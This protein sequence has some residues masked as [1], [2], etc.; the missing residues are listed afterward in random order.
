MEEERLHLGRSAWQTPAQ[1]AGL[2]WLE[3]NGLGGW[4]FGTVPNLNTRFYHGV[5]APSLRPPTERIVLLAKVDE[6]VVL[7]GQAHPLYSNAWEGGK[8]EAGGLTY[9]HSFALDPFPTWTFMIGDTLIRKRLFMRHGSNTTVIRYHVRRGAGRGPVELKLFPL[10]TC[11]TI[12]G[13]LRQ[14]DWPFSQEL[15][16]S[17][18]VS[19]E[20]YVG[21]PRL[22]MAVD[23]GSYAMG[24]EWVV[25][26]H[27]PYEV[28]RGEHTR[29]DLYLPGSFTWRCQG[30]GELTFVASTDPVGLIDGES[31]EDGERRRRQA[32]VSQAV[33]RDRFTAA[34]VQAAD[35]FIV[36]RESTGT[37]T[38]IAGYPWFTDW[39][40]DTMI[41]L[42]GLTLST[43]RYHLARQLLHTFAAYERDGLIPNCFPEEGAEP[44]YNTADASLWFSEAVWQYLRY[45]GDDRFVRD[46]LYPVLLR[47]AEAHVKGTRFD[48]RVTADGLLRCGNPGVQVTWMDA[49][50][51]NWVVT[52]RDGRPVE[53]QALWYNALCVLAELSRRYDRQE[54]ARR[55]GVMADQVAERFGQ[56][57]WNEAEGCCYDLLADDGCPD[58]S[59]RPNQLFTMTLAHPLI[60]GER[61]RSTVDVLFRELWTPY[62]LRSLSPRDPAYKGF[63]EGNRR[64]RDGAYHQGTVWGWLAAPF[65][66][67]YLHAYGRSPE[68]I[69]HV[70][71]LLEPLRAHLQ[72]FGLGSIAENFD[73]D[74]PH[75]ARACVAQ[76][77]SVAETLS[78]WRDLHRTFH[79]L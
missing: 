57:F 20:P 18:S 38:V 3:T 58:P 19:V 72:E 62:G 43:R 46:E 32:L 6:Q 75:R 12:H 26:L 30:D 76:A 54:E 21:A 63:Y 40:R 29:E 61:A 60:G 33:A 4:A 34:L 16:R 64:E 69:A 50:V 78:L 48:I 2:E 59:I 10:V 11:R 74:P 27:Y 14:N 41:A 65:L 7:D 31:W 53:I 47:I 37:S 51:E 17:G 22:H 15:L 70:R 68:R 36:H 42:H 23:G 55:W 66:R 25:G 56:A 39:G 77:W 1:G 67:A 49:K 13:V 35:Q 45:T 73:G 52:P 44:L 28:L 9:L 79:P 24:G 5:L 8:T 71:Q